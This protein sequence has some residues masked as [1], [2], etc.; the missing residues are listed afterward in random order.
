M[1]RYLL[2]IVLVLFLAVLLWRVYLL[3]T[4]STDDKSRRFNRPPV[5]VEVDSVRIGPIQEVKML[6]GTVYPHYQYIIAPKVS[7]RLIEIR[8]RIGDW[9]KG[10]EV[11]ARID[12]AE[13]QQ[14]LL[15]AEANLKIAQ[16]ALNETIGQ[17]ELAKQELERVESLQAK[18]IASPAELDAAVNNHNAQGSR[19][20]LAQAQVE[21]R[22]ASLQSAKIRIG[23]TTLTAN[24]PGF[25]GERFVDEGSLLAPNSAVVSV[26]GIDT[27]IIRTTIIERVYGLLRAE[28][29]CE[30]Q[31]DAYPT[32]SFPGR[33]ARIAPMLIE[34][35]RVA[36]ME[37][38]VTNDSLILKPGMFARV[39][40][41]LADKAS[42]Q[43]IP[44]QAVVNRND[45]T[46]VFLIKSN[47]TVA[48]YIPVQ[49]GIT[50]SDYTEILSPQ[51]NGLIVTL[52]QHLLENESPVILPDRQNE[53]KVKTGKE[54]SSAR[55]QSTEEPP[56]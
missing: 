36:Q 15:E 20:K 17:F 23:Y 11:I 14:A 13:Y 34:S 37:V 3:I 44:G 22:E 35:S 30:V 2:R 38:E 6:T 46:G 1:K 31:V 24:Q 21:Q 8:K 33:V 47:E 49:L 56:K 43:I 52:G 26:I 5:A 39:K 45:T 29:M 40:V 51:L 12:D 48:C 10:G 4:K 54:A 55:R 7:G 53:S 16:A 25:I 28:Q 42:A 27:V 9:V 19:L 32:K 50:S 18:G 41:V